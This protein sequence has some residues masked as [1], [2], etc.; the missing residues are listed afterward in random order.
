MLGEIKK[1][2]YGGDYIRFRSVCK[3]WKAVQHHET[4]P[5]DVLPWLMVI[6]RENLSTINYYFFEPS[7]PHLRPVISETIYLDQFFDISR[8]DDDSSV[9]FIHRDGCLVISVSDIQA[10]GLYF[11]LLT[12][13]T[14]KVCTIPQLHYPYSYIYGT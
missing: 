2:L 11:L 7:A 12:L 14:K 10:T 5:A 6:K 4:R 8:I 3:S 13:R 9:S 1:K